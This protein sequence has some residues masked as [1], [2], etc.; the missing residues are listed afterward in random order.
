MVDLSL[1]TVIKVDLPNSRDVQDRT[2]DSVESQN[3]GCNTVQAHKYG[4]SECFGVTCVNCSGMSMTRRQVIKWTHLKISYGHYRTTMPRSWIQRKETPASCVKPW[5]L[6]FSCF[7]G[8]CSCKRWLRPPCEASF[9]AGLISSS[10]TLSNRK[11]KPSDRAHL[12]H[13]KKRERKEAKGHT[14]LIPSSSLKSS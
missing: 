9:S 10:R 3:P 8:S 7:W 13:E 4:H 5:N 2:Q 12:T 14:P 6:D 1:G 11:G